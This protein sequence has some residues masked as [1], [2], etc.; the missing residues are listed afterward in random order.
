MCNIRRHYFPLSW[1]L[2]IITNKKE[3]ISIYWKEMSKK[4]EP[5]IPWYCGFKSQSLLH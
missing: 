3:A 5:F 1:N 2:K 4:V